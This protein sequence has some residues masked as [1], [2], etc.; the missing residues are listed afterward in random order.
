MQFRKES[1]IGFLV[2]LAIHLGLLVVIFFAITKKDDSANGIDADVVDT[3]ISMEMIMAMRVAEA[4]PEPEPEIKQPEEP[5]EEVVADPT[6]KPKPEKPKE[7]EKKKE[8]P[9][10]KPKDKPKEK[11]KDKPKEPVTAK[12]KASVQNPQAQLG[13]REIAGNS[14]VNSTAS[15]IG[16]A[17]SNNT[18]LSGSGSNSSEAAAYKSKLRREIERNKRYSQRAK[19]MRKQGIVTVSFTINNDGSL[20]NARV[21]KSSGHDD[22]DKSA[23]DAVL[24]ANSIG[25]R[26]AAVPAGLSVPIRFTLQ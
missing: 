13:D 15:S 20:S 10:E 9:K 12:V 17:N 25:P 26:P 2:S 11:P 1:G 24:N 16:A 3:N 22:L 18:N 14:N 23:L 21:T 7:P 8:K 19:M 6:I 5:K 4:E